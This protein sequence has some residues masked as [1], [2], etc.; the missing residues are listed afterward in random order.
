MSQNPL[1]IEGSRS[2]DARGSISFNNLF[3]AAE[4]KRIYFIENQSLEF[5]RGWQGHKLE[6][7]WFACVNGSFEIRVVYIDNWE[8]PSNDSSINIF[9]LEA[10]NLDVLYVPN[11]YVTSIQALEIGSKLMAMS[12]YLLGELKDEYRFE[13]NYFK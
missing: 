12:D 9:H 2:S 6:Q 11:G 7:R 1:I 13:S 4:V 8:N 3:N 5:I 10:I